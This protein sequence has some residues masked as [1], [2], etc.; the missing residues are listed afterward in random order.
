MIDEA[1]LRELA[2][3][4][5]QLPVME[6]VQAKTEGHPFYW[7][8]RPCAKGHK[9]QRRTSDG[10]CCAC[11]YL[12][13]ATSKENS[14]A[15]HKAKML[16]IQERG[17]P[18]VGIG[19]RKQQEIL[20]RYAKTGSLELAAKIADLTVPQLNVQLAKSAVFAA[21]MTA[22]ER[23]LKVM[24]ANEK[25]E[26]YAPCNLIWTDDLR[27]RFITAYIDTGSKAE[28]REA[29]G[30]SSS[31]YFTEI[32]ENSDFASRVKEAEPKANQVLE[33]IAIGMA[34]K[35]NDKLLT[36]ILKAKIPEYGD[37]LKIEQT[38]LSFVRLSDDALQSRV[39]ELANKYSM[40]IDGSIADDSSRSRGIAGLLGRDGS[41]TD[42]EQVPISVS[43][44]RAA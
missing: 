43:E 44:D 41:E 30:A 1:K 34:K 33:E 17:G 25:E 23:R 22:L 38:S 4:G 21:K 40:V 32:A 5:P 19:V 3:N 15:L 42:E 14:A 36:A 8:G 18:E 29:V 13:D 11:K 12:T 16:E 35:G 20:E 10:T 9:A 28:A 26:E 39:L 27:N 2:T 37:K 6:R 31:N 7:V 24:K